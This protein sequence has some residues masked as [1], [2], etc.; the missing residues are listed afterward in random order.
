MENKTEGK[1]CNLIN[2]SLKESLGNEKQMN[3]DS[4]K[5]MDLIE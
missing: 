5:R 3:K 2:L 4:L 1:K